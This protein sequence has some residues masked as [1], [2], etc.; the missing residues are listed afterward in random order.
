MHTRP[1]DAVT[2][3]TC[4]AVFPVCLTTTVTHQISATLWSHGLGRTFVYLFISLRALSVAQL[5]H[6]LSIAGGVIVQ[7]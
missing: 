6:L 2:G 5:M 7:V 3:L 1:G 4:T